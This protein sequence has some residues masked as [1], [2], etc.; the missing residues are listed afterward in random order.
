MQSI[1][2]HIIQAR[3]ITLC[4]TKFIS[5]QKKYVGKK[6]IQEMATAKKIL[7]KHSKQSNTI[8]LQEYDKFNPHIY[9]FSSKKVVAAGSFA[10][11]ELAYLNVDLPEPRSGH[12]C[13]SDGSNLY[14]VGGYSQ[15]RFRNGLYDTDLLTLPK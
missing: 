13:F 6:K 15:D 10:S 5:Q 11:L 14:V 2:I 3:H 12:C 1:L 8:Q 7:Y 9:K 4:K